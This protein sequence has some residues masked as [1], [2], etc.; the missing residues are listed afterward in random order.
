MK[1][2]SSRSL[3]HS[4]DLGPASAEDDFLSIKRWNKPMD[5]FHSFRM[6]VLV[7]LH[8]HSPEM[9][10]ERADNNQLVSVVV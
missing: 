5:L 3:M 7:L 8:F 9:I 1:A 4:S 6:V 2:S 10:R